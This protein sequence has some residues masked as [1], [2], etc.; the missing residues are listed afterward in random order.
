[1]IIAQTPLKSGQALVA[2]SVGAHVR[3]SWLNSG[4]FDI[5]VALSEE[6]VVLRI[7]ARSVQSKPRPS[8]ILAFPGEAKTP[9]F[10]TLSTI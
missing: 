3:L 7:K 5:V 8:V 1:V 2:L 4:I 10:L 6:Y 9:P